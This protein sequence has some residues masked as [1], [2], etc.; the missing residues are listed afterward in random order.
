MN[1]VKKALSAAVIFSLASIAQA[2]TYTYELANV[3]SAYG[4]VNYPGLDLNGAKS[5]I[6]TVNRNPGE[7]PEIRSLEVTFPNAAKLSTG[8]F[9][10]LDDG[11]YR[12][13]VSGA[14]VFKEVI[15][16]FD[17]NPDI[18][19][20]TPASISVSVSETTSLLN[21]EALNQGSRLVDVHGI[22]RDITNMATM[23]TAAI[24]FD[25]KGLTLNLKDR[26]GI[27][28]TGSQQGFI[29]DAL[30]MGRGQ[31]LIYLPG[32]F[33][34]SQ[35]DRIDPIGIVLEGPNT[36]PTIRVRFKD[37]GNEQL[38]PPVPLRVLMQQSFPAL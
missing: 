14:W 7:R 35:W 1:L 6:L 16:Q 38:S 15:V 27:S 10:R 12:A 3:N 31:K 4:P 25:G 8:A 23:D 13:L 11:R 19:T 32:P 5:A 18:F 30:W 36:D 29:L 20:N 33:G 37:N 22:V 28:A 9:K 2:K 26:L 24:V 34:P 17:G 21:P